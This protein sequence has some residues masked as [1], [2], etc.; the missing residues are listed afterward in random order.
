MT[1][2]NWVTVPDVFRQLGREAVPEHTWSVGA[3]VR[4]MWER[5]FERLP[6]KA[7]RPKTNDGGTHV[8]AV[9][10]PS[11]RDKIIAVIHSIE[12]EAAKQ[13]ELFT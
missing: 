6:D 7:L 2:A 5:E 11:W 12:T 4:D 9:Y 8:L 1:T 3:V 13:M 10:P